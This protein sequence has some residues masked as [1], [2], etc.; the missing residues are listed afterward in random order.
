MFTDW[1]SWLVMFYGAY[2]IMGLVAAAAIASWA[3]IKLSWR[4]VF[5]L[6]RFAAWILAEFA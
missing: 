5:G 2:I 6:V 1:L 4:L 3:L